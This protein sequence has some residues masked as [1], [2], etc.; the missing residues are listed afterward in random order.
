M[1]IGMRN[2]KTGIA[3]MLCVLAGEFIVRNPMYAGIGCLVSIQ[4]TFKGSLKFGFNRVKGTAIGGL[5]G[6]ISLFIAQNNPIICGIGAMITV[7]ICTNLKIN[8]GIIVACVT[9]LSI[10][11]GNIDTTPMDYSLHRVL[12][13]LIGV[14]IG[15][16]VNLI[17]RPNYYKK[18]VY[19]VNKISNL[20][21]K[22]I[23]GKIIKNEDFKL[24]LISK[25]VIS[26]EINF[27][28]LKDEIQVT[29]EEVD[30]NFFELKIEEYKEII[31]H[32]NS[33]ELL[34]NELFIDTKNSE[35]L[36]R[37]YSSISWNLDDESCPVFNYHLSK[38]IDVVYN[39]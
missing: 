29:K 19:E 14:F 1:K 21:E 20:I 5:I 32:M 17:G 7:Y 39:D 26:L 30:I 25:E 16:F 12:D 3:V 8:S 37:F 4:D 33:I 36:K 13:T 18:C 24:D 9:F 15:V 22:V 34:Q 27:M 35:R 38:I 23:E 10:N 2:I 31:S 11:L 6:F 28:K